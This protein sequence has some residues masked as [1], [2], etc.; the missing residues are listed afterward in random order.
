MNYDEPS[1]LPKLKNCDHE[2]PFITTGNTPRKPKEL[3][4]YGCLGCLI[5]ILTFGI[6]IILGFLVWIIL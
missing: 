2:P 6:W 3:N 5:V 4:L 1:T